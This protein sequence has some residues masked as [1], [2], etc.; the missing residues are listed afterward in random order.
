MISSRYRSV[1]GK[2]DDEYDDDDDVTSA[3]G[4]HYGGSHLSN[5]ASFTPGSK[6]PVRAGA[7][8]SLL[9]SLSVA[10]KN[11]QLQGD[12]QKPT[13]TSLSS[14]ASQKGKAAAAAAAAPA[15]KS[16]AAV[17]GSGSSSLASLAAKKG[18]N[19]ASSGISAALRVAP[20]RGLGF[21]HSEDL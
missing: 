9:S 12:K 16:A 6:L 21:S 8:P 11:P 3:R 17:S 20:S 7:A 14:L 13:A 5:A 4:G 10:Q 2:S 18:Y 19:S 1:I 15:G